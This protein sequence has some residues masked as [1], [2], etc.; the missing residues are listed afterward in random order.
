M[1]A[2]VTD[3]SSFRKPDLEGK[4]HA[5]RY[6]SLL[7]LFHLFGSCALCHSSVEGFLSL[8]TVFLNFPRSL[9]KSSVCLY[10]SQNM[11]SVCL[12][13]LSFKTDQHKSCPA[14]RL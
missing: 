3:S 11:L 10:V 7:T 13:C 2:G 5:I 1:A 8:S 12:E 9:D 14:L 6:L 4:P